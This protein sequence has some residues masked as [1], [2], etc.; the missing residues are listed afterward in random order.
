MWLHNS[1]NWLL[2]KLISRDKFRGCFWFLLHHFFKFTDTAVNYPNSAVPF[3]FQLKPDRLRSFSKNLLLIIA[4]Y[5]GG[6][7]L[8]QGRPVQALKYFV[9]KKQHPSRYRGVGVM[10]NMNRKKFLLRHDGCV[11]NDSKR[12]RQW[13]THLRFDEN[14]NRFRVT[15]VKI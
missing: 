12:R 8:C 7:R 14:G 1:S 5:E 13:A 2:Q 6:D 4:D 10:S 15:S 11:R 9:S 3:R